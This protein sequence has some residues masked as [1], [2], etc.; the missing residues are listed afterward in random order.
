MGPGEGGG[1]PV[2]AAAIGDT[3]LSR[4]VA[5]GV[6]AFVRR[7]R[8]V[9]EAVA[10]LHQAV[11]AE[12]TKRLRFLFALARRLEAARA[13]GA[14][15]TPETARRLEVLRAEPGFSSRREPPARSVRAAAAALAARARGFNR[16]WERYLETVSIEEVRGLQRA[17]N[18]WY[19]LEREMALR[20]PG[21]PFRELPFLERADLHR[22][23]P[24][25]PM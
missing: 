18:R 9:E 15:L 2:L 23:F 19:P 3:E 4:A 21:L 20:Q 14:A 12:R 22:R 25:L 6:P 7:G 5:L 11:A 8:A 16:R 13:A 10:A 17:Y 1:E 24:P